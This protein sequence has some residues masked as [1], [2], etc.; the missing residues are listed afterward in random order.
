VLNCLTTK[1]GTMVE[2]SSHTLSIDHNRVKRAPFQKYC[3]WIRDR[4]FN[5]TDAYVLNL[6]NGEKVSPIDLAGDLSGEVKPKK[7]L[8][9]DTVLRHCMGYEAVSLY[10]ISE[11]NTCKWVCLDIDDHDGT[12]T[13]QTTAYMFK[14]VAAIREM[15]F[16][17][18]VENSDGGGGW[19]IW[20]LFR[21]PVLSEVAYRFGH[22]LVESY[23]LPS[24]SKV[25]AEVFPTQEC[26]TETS[27]Y[28]SAVRV[29]GK[30]PKRGIWSQILADGE[31]LELPSD[32]AIA[33][34]AS[35]GGNSPMLIPKEVRNYQP[36]AY[37]RR[38]LG[39]RS[40]FPDVEYDEDDPS[41]QAVFSRRTSWEAILTPHGW[42]VVQVI[43]KVTYWRRPEKYIGGH[44]ATTGY[45][46][47]RL[48]VFSGDSG[49]RPF[50][51]GETYSKWQAHVLLN[52]GGDSDAAEGDYLFNNN[53]P[54]KE[55]E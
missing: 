26:L 32:E 39:G 53:Q 30:H 33:W 43:G 21:E 13:E 3:E 38:W 46:G 31:P 8:T 37:K 36:Q 17:P 9:S 47:S 40:E 1:G 15:G 51:K 44:S 18:L 23:C 34:L 28:G 52:F 55:R 10:A 41:V 54:N 25:T 48:Y 29:P 16:E 2:E 35:Y 24:D 45:C 49:C 11:A 14:L 50:V 27:R 12:T 6:A 22:W 4:L 42:T 5:R 7:P 20:V 19:H